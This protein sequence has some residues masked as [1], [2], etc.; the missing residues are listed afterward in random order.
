M[1]LPELDDGQ[2]FGIILTGG[3][4]WVL[5]IRHAPIWWPW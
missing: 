1:K 5:I 4:C 3:L 2:I